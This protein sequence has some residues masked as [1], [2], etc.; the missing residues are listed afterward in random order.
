VHTA[1]GAQRSLIISSEAV[2]RDSGA[3]DVVESSVQQ[4]S[5]EELPEGGLVMLKLV[6]RTR[7]GEE[8]STTHSAA[9][10]F[11]AYLAAICIVALVL[12]I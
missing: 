2:V 9:A 10:I 4:H 12:S 8:I 3:L 1:N 7:R 5:I 6:A 11:R